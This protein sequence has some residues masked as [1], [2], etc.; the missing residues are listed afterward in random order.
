MS[1]KPKDERSYIQYITVTYRSVLLAILLIVMLVSA[2]SYFLFPQQTKALVSQVVDMLHLDSPTRALAK[3]SGQQQAHFTNID[4]TV[5]VKRNNSSF[6]ANA[7]YDLPLNKG[8]VV[9]TGP[10]GIAKVVFAD[11]TNYTIQQ[12][13]LIV[14]EDNSTNEAQQTQVAV[15][16]TT[17]TVD[18][19]TATYSQGS[20]ARVIVA[21]ATAS[22]SPESSAQVHNDNLKN[23]H[24]IL[25]KQGSGNVLRN[26][27][28]VK[29]GSYERISFKAEDPKMTRVKEV[30]PPTLITPANMLPVFAAKDASQLDF[31]W[32]P[33]QN[34]RAYHLRISKNPYFTQLVQDKTLAVPQF[35]MSGLAEGPYYWTVQSVDAQGRESVESEHNKFTIIAQAGNAGL[36]LELDPLVQHGH[37]IEV[38][39]KTDP[40]ARVM[41]NGEEVPVVGGDGS[42]RYYTPPLPQGESVITVTAQNTKGGV[43]TQTKKVVVQ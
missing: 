8:D 28:V 18:L 5:R 26:G 25:L 23:D 4:G 36:A 21:G 27:E 12:E 42:F 13:S 32:T 30:G 2:V 40:S 20:T 3:E 37:V 14:I 43:S 29:L 17:G 1:P 6:W 31:T 35:K 39:G 41:V 24:S 16:V 34:T 19:A 33:M 15:Q 11:G 7:S 9:Q 10:E 22:L 38:R